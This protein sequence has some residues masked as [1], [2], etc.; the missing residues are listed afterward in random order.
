MEVS[1]K[2]GWPDEGFHEILNEVFHEIFKTGDDQ[3][4]SFIYNNG[5]IARFV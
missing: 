4:Y 1:W 3:N 5:Y 2:E